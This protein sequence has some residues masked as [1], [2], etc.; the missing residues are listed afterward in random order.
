M[1][2][3][4][5]L[6]PTQ[7]DRDEIPHLLRNSELVTHHRFDCPKHDGRWLRQTWSLT[8]KNKP[9]RQSLKQRQKIANELWPLQFTPYCC[10]N[11]SNP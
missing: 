3:H 10:R 7:V 4:V 1:D 5:F 8:T 2:A 11:A 9:D 6:Y